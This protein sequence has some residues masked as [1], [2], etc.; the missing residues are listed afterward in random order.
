MHRFLR[1][2][3]LLVF[4]LLIEPIYA[5][6]GSGGTIEGTVTDP[7]SAVVAGAQITVT[8]TETGVVTIARSTS[9][10]YYVAPALI[11]GVYS[12][13][14]ERSGFKSYVQQNISVNA[15]QV[16]GLNIKLSVGETTES[17]TVTTAPPALETK[18][19]TH[20]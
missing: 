5:Q 7:L 11:P 3:S 6:T 8:N 15:L 20:R 19:R 2:F 12:V 18:Q 14:V 17:V 10:G 1:F 9:A 4:A 16:V 13:Q